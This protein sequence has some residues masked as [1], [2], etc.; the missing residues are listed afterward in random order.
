MGV[1]HL[2]THSPV[3]TRWMRTCTKPDDAHGIQY[4]IQ[5][6]CMYGWMDGWVDGLMYGWMDGWVDGWMYG[7]MDGC[8]L[9]YIIIKG[10]LVS[11]I[12]TAIHSAIP[13]LI[14][15]CRF[16]WI[17][18]TI[19]SFFHAPHNLNLS[20]PQITDIPTDHCFLTAMFFVK[21]CPGAAGQYWYHVCNMYVCIL[22]LQLPHLRL[23]TFFILIHHKQINN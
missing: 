16:M 20:L 23:P 5:I 9:I 18:T 3:S 10:S 7:W 11:L 4:M 17:S 15:S 6:V 14:F 8:I 1:R 13:A 12:H 22:E 2:C 19:C 21:T